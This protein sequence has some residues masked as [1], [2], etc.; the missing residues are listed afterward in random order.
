MNSMTGSLED[1]RKEDETVDKLLKKIATQQITIDKIQG[2]YKKLVKQNEELKQ[3]IRK[4]KKE[5]ENEEENNI[6]LYP[7]EKNIPIEELEEAEEEA[8]KILNKGDSIKFILDLIKTRH[9]GDENAAEGILISISNQS[10]LNSMGIHTV[11]NGESGS[12]KSHLFKVILKL[13]P[14][15]F[16]F[17]TSL[18]NKAIYYM[19]I[20][21]G[22]IIYSDDTEM[23]QE[24]EEIFKRSSTN[25]QEYTQYTTVIDH[26]GSTKTIP[27]RLNW[28]LTSVD[29]EASD[30]VLNRQLTFSTVTD[31]K[32]KEDIYK[33]QQKEIV[34]GEISSLNITKEVLVC[35]RIFNEIKKKT[36]YVK[37]PFGDR[38][39][40]KSVSDSRITTMF[41][42]M[43]MG[44]TIFNFMQ[45]EKDD[46]GKFI[47]TLKDFYR[48]KKLFE[49][50]QNNIVTKLNERELKVVQYIA[51]HQKCELNDIVRDL[52]LE[53]NVAYRL[54]NGRKGKNGTIQGGLLSKVPGLT[55]Y[56]RTESEIDIDPDTDYK[57]PD[58]RIS[59]R[60]VR[61]IIKN[62]EIWK[63]YKSDFIIL[64]DETSN[65]NPNE[66][67]QSIP[68]Y[69]KSLKSPAKLKA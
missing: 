63:L 68:N 20:K 16:V 67:A 21:E 18:S 50:Q 8:L 59:T 2:K 61:Y 48:A 4:E 57:A 19:N 42:N 33:M 47:A 13:L 17:E 10:C 26:K 11:F 66:V 3:G 43:I 9:A 69:Y 27:P 44:Y 23:S 6:Y 39:V 65:V 15:R 52:E 7:D 35:R 58:K 56:D 28:Y 41:F 45:R 12:G 30:Q 31:Y 54:M 34:N 49:S 24:I 38:I 32:H 37:I 55:K 46:D 14:S 5:E 64:I 40:M 22:S 60:A 25:Y 62:P 51:E 36:F 53:S 29:N 1:K